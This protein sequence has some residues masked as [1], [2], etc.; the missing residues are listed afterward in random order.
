[1]G[2]YPESGKNPEGLTGKRK[3]ILD[4]FIDKITRDLKID[5]IQHNWALLLTKTMSCA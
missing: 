2:N 5:Q 4:S 1:M 3:S